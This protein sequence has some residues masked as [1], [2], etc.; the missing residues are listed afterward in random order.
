MAED[1]PLDEFVSGGYFL[2]QPFVPSP[3]RHAIYFPS[4]LVQPPVVTLSPCLA[5]VVP[6]EW[7]CSNWLPLISQEYRESCAAEWG[8]PSHIVAELFT[9]CLQRVE[10]GQILHHDAF[11]DLETAREFAL[12]FLPPR[13][14]VR[15]LGIGLHRDLQE[16]LFRAVESEG[17]A[18][19]GPGWGA[20]NGVLEG[21]RRRL[22]LATGGQHLGYE[23]LD[24][25]FGEQR[26]SWLC[27]GL[28]RRMHD[29]QGVRLLPGGLISTYDQACRVAAHCDDPANHC[30]RGVWRAWRVVNYDFAA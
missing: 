17:A 2:I 9:W 18:K 29:E 26:H 16:G 7:A 14:D 24:I 20:P 15:L 28:E 12:R 4:D 23:V 27:H 19:F 1:P 25:A 30:E 11:A 5:E 21:V 8:I 13:S 10:E 6:D 22:P 3:D